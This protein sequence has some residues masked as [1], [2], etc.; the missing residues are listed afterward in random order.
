MSHC[1]QAIH[2]GVLGPIRGDLILGGI[3]IVVQSS[4]P[5]PQSRKGWAAEDLSSLPYKLFHQ[6]THH[7]F[8]RAQPFEAGDH[9]FRHPKVIACP[10]R[11]GKTVNCFTFIRVCK[12]A[13]TVC[14]YWATPDEPAFRDARDRSIHTGI[15]PRTRRKRLV[16]HGT[17][18]SSD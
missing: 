15:N 17:T 16:S 5:G 14:D 4:R 3:A 2:S 11:F 18:L 7:R 13:S 1:V 9:L 6:H 10:S 8:H 12:P